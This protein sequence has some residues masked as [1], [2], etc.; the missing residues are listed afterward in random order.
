MTNTVELEVQIV[1]AG[2][3]KKDL[4]ERLHISHTAFFNKMNNISEFKASEIATLVD[5][6]GMSREQRDLIFF[7]QKC[8]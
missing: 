7:G 5:A 3:K 4:I 8:E 2:V 6:L 1:R